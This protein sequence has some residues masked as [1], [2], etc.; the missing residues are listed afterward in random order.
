MPQEYMPASDFSDTAGYKYR[1]K[2][3]EDS[4]R[5][6]SLPHQRQYSRTQRYRELHNGKGGVNRKQSQYAADHQSNQQVVASGLLQGCGRIHF[7]PFYP[8]PAL[9]WLS[10]SVNC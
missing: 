7:Q 9:R 5:S 8:F 6:A 1:A 4:H 3:D 2:Q 10:G